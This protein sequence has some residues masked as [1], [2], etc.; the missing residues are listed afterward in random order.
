MHMQWISESIKNLINL[1][2]N[3]MK[4]QKLMLWI[5]YLEE[6]PFNLAEFLVQVS[7]VVIQGLFYLG[8]LVQ[9]FRH[10]N[11][12]SFH[13]RHDFL[14]SMSV[15][16]PRSH[17]VPRGSWFSLLRL[18]FLFRRPWL[19]RNRMFVTSGPVATLT[20][21]SPGSLRKAHKFRYHATM[22]HARWFFRALVGLTDGIIE[23][24]SV[25]KIWH[26]LFTHLHAR[27]MTVSLKTIGWPNV[28]WHT[29]GKMIALIKNLHYQT[30]NI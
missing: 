2:Q 4:L 7:C 17:L 16:L 27:K 25:P 19:T 24:R 28:C 21:S 15:P 30:I 13:F 8:Q 18:V 9:G 29:N 23:V 26:L 1:F 20:Q 6:I 14:V 5:G 3:L 12:Y 22:T 10:C 11:G